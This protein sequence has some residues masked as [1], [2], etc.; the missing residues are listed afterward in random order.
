MGIVLYTQALL[1]AGERKSNRPRQSACVCGKKTHR[2]KEYWDT[3][4]RR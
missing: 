2:K 1:A 4:E 3:D